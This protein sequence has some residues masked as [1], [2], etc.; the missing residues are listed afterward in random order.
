MTPDPHYKPG[1]TG[2]LEG[3]KFMI[4][5]SLAKR[6]H[7][8]IGQRTKIS[9]N[10]TPYLHVTPEL[11]PQSSRRPKTAVEFRSHP[12]PGYTGYVPKSHDN[13]GIGE[14]Y[15][16]RATNGFGSQ[17][18][19]Y[20][21]VRSK[22][23]NLRADEI[24]KLQARLETEGK[25]PT[26]SLG[27]HPMAHPHAPGKLNPKEIKPLNKPYF[28]DNSNQLRFFKSGYTGYLPRSRDY[29]AVGLTQMS[30][31]ALQ[32]MDAELATKRYCPFPRQEMKPNENCEKDTRIT[33]GQGMKPGYTGYIP[34][35]KFRFAR[36]YGKVSY[37]AFNIPAEATE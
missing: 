13:Q 2:Y 32:R 6:S 19:H 31:S 12:P 29:F 14:R 5:G 10:I 36:T 30:N 37:D 24:E 7:T 22:M 4:G 3:N 16:I 8:S 9:P 27:T 34:G 1:Y 11:T 20:R 21:R 17:E 26:K 18:R 35:S 33:F 28:M 25:P 15:A 23:D